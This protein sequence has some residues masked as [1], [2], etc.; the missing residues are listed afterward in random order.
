MP[1]RVKIVIPG[2]HPP[3]IAG[4]P[5]LALLEPYGDVTLHDDT[6][7]SREAKLER[8]K[9][10]VVIMNTRGAVTWRAP[11]L[12]ALP[13]VRLIATCSVGTDM[14]DLDA[15]RRRGIVVANQPGRNA[16]YVA[17]HM[18]GLMF[19]VAKRAA[20]CTE[21]LRAG[22]WPATMNATLAGKTLGVVGTGATGAAMAGLARTFGMDVVAWT[23]NPS[24]ERARELGVRY[25]ELDELLGTADVVSLHV[26]LTADTRHLVGERELALMKPTAILL[27]GARGDVVDNAALARALDEGALFGAGID[28]FSTEPCPPDDP[29]LRCENVVLTSHRADQTPEA[30]DA[31]NLGVVENVIGFL[32]GRPIPNAAAP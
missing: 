11:D 12:E 16:P 23:F 3:Q 8:V 4:S 32:E 29:I 18:F 30:V 10:A 19:A 31:I 5:H 13:K 28:V 25:L 15:A 7:Q 26:K 27:N 1:D 14:I 6:P 24:A 17:E 20:W 22:R 2:D 21:E 9:D